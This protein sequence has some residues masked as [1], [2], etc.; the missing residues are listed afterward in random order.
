MHIHRVQVRRVARAAG[1]APASA[2]QQW[3][4]DPA[5]W[6]VEQDADGRGRAGARAL[7]VELDASGAPESWVIRRALPTREQESDNP[8]GA[9]AREVVI[10]ARRLTS[11]FAAL[12][13]ALGFGR[14]DRHWRS[15]AALAESQRI[16]KAVTDNL[17]GSGIFGVELFVAGD[18]VWFSEVSPRPHDTGLVTLISQPQSEF[19]LHVRALL[20]VPLPYNKYMTAVES[21][22]TMTPSRV[23]LEATI[24]VFD[25]AAVTGVTVAVAA[26]LGSAVTTP[27]VGVTIWIGFSASL[28]TSTAVGLFREYLACGISVLT[29]ESPTRLAAARMRPR[30]SHRLSRRRGPPGPAWPAR[31][32]HW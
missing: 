30:I 21:L 11:S 27:P 32:G 14:A 5:F 25:T 6:S 29:R 22:K 31:T 19:A 26:R 1:D 8:V 16:A 17:G 10:K 15:A 2:W 4:S 20:G 3:L 9:G 28:T 24:C 23:A 13:E 7:K 18:M 12:K